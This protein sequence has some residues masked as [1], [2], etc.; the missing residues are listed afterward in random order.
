[1]AKD[2]ETALQVIGVDLGD[3]YSQVC[4]L[5]VDGAV[6]EESR[7]T[8]TKAAFSRQFSGRPRSRVVLETGTHANWVHDLL[9]GGWARSAGRECAQGACDLGE[10]AQERP[11]RRADAGSTWSSRCRAAVS[12]EGSWRGLAP[13]SFAVA[14]SRGVG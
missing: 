6:A 14:S 1:M 13:G 2:S 3:R 8:T 5:D 7:L 10:R 4:V 9:A 12:G 11:G